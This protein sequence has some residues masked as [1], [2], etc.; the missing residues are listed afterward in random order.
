MKLL[1]FLESAFGVDFAEIEFDPQ[2]FDTV[3]EI[4]ALIEESGAP[5]ALRPAMPS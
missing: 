5:A 1:E 4:V 2:R 3:D